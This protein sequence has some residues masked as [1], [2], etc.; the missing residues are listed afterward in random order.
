MVCFSSELVL[1]AVCHEGLSQEQQAEGNAGYKMEKLMVVIL[2]VCKLKAW[3][4]R[5]NT[6]LHGMGSKSLE[7][8]S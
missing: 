1:S 7:L 4:S 3:V 6:C 2:E 8:E 5:E